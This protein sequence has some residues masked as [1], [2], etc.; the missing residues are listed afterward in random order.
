MLN[1][2]DFVCECEEN[3]NACKCMRIEVTE[4]IN[5]GLV[6]SLKHAAQPNTCGFIPFHYYI[7]FLHY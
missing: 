2:L 1:W 7:I 6:F 3:C 5:N 4:F